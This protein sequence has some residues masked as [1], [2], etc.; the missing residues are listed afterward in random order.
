MSAAAR[1]RSTSFASASRPAT[2]DGPGL[3]V[4]IAHAEAPDTVEELR[5]LVLATRPAAE[6]EVVG[7]LGAVVG[8]HAG[9]GTVGFFWFQDGA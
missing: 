8:T 1:R 4:G 6:I 5:A 7:T 2:S 9:P 3:V